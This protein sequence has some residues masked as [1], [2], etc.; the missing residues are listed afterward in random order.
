MTVPETIPRPAVSR[1]QI[2]TTTG[3]FAA[4]G[5]LV[6]AMGSAPAKAAVTTRPL[7]IPPTSVEG[8]IAVEV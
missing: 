6:A 8:E 3:T 1:R 4:G 7:D 2:L 5:G